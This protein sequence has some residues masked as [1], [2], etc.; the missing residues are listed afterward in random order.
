[1]GMKKR[2]KPLLIKDLASCS[3][4]ISLPMENWEVIR[5]VMP[6]GCHQIFAMKI[7]KAN[8]HPLTKGVNAG[9]HRMT[10]VIEY[11][12]Y[13]KEGNEIHG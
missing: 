10:L 6:E 3:E 8:Y 4:N 2:E 1:M 5:R 12:N 9:G 13:D 7:T 11:M